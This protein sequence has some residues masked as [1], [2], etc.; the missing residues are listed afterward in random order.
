M[1]QQRPV[2]TGTLGHTVNQPSPDLEGRPVQVNGSRPAARRN[3]VFR[4]TVTH[5]SSVP[6]R[7][8]IASQMVASAAAMRTGP[9]TTSPGR[10]NS[11]RNRTSSVHV[12]SPRARTRKRQ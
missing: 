4:S 8:A 5:T 2:F 10:R 1:A 11:S 12:P 9:L 6:N 7:V 3:A